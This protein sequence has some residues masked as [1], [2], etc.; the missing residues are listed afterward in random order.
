VFLLTGA[1]GSFEAQAVEVVTFAVL[2]PNLTEL[3]RMARALSAQTHPSAAADGVP[4]L[5][6]AV[7][8]MRWIVVFH[9]AL[10]SRAQATL[11]TLTHATLVGPVAV[12]TEDT[13]GDGV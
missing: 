11:V 12:A 8:I 9:R 4:W 3:I 2:S 1:Q 10:A 7:D 13:V 6:Y 5:R